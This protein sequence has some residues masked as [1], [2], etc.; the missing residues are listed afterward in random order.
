MHTASPLPVKPPTDE[1]ECV[2]PALEGTLAVMRAAAKHKVKRVVIT[3]SGLTVTMMKTEN[4]KAVYNEDDWADL[5]VL[6]PYEKSKTLAEKAAWDFVKELPEDQKFELVSV[7]PGLVQ[8]PP[9]V[10]SDFSSAFYMKLMMLGLMPGLPKIMF[11]VVDVRNVAEA[12]LNAIKIEEAKN[13]RFLLVDDTYKFKELSDTLRAHYGE[14][15]PFKTEELAESP[16]D[17]VRFKLL[18]DKV[19][20][21]DNS[22]SKN[23]LGI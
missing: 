7:I 17:N 19:Y 14:K 15:Y 12:H 20:K 6:G 10:F 18:W 16:P 8:G 9:I 1:N 13:Q 2:K 23:I 22:K 5:E 21:V 11:P 4:M 3:S